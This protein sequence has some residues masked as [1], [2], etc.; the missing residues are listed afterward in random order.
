MSYQFKRVTPR[1]MRPPTRADRK[2]RESCEAYHF[3]SDMPCQMLCAC[4]ALPYEVNKVTANQ[5]IFIKDSLKMPVS[6]NSFPRSSLCCD[7]L[8][9]RA[10]CIALV[11]WLRHSSAQCPTFEPGFR[12][13]DS[14]LDCQ[15][16]ILAEPLYAN[17]C[18]QFLIWCN[19]NA[20]V[21]PT[22]V[23]ALY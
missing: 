4:P 8:K 22:K 21:D 23:K 2:D 11:C 1:A 19:K 10:G 14:L 20:F 9:H 18:D 6:I 13:C 7:L 17:F 15:S 16:V 3:V 5:L 12:V